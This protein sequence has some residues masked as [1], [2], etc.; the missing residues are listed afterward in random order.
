MPRTALWTS[1][2]KT[3]EQEITTGHYAA[4]DKLPTEAQLSDRFGVNR[5][6][7]RRALVDLAES[8][9]VYAR[10]GA[11][12]F[13]THTPTDYP[14]GRRVRFTQSITATGRTPGRKV[15]LHETRA[16]DPK[17]ADALA[18]QPGAPVHVSEGLSLVDSEVLAMS[19][20]VYPA[21]R[22]PNFLRHLQHEQ[23][24][25]AAFKAEGVADYTRASTRIDAKL[26]SPTLALHLQLPQGA[27]I[28][29]TI[30]INVD[31]DGVP[32]EYGRTWFAGDRVTLTL[33]EDD[34][35]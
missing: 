12:V 32:I 3:L 31:G 8:G 20:G 29:R 21:E 34:V 2:R 4:G 35:D 1:I 10:R 25:T 9:L 33:A 26:A 7:I 18:I 24:V 11:G 27:P 6:T 17:E 5:H 23:S 22:F 15:L 13:V 16:A 14:I 30:G 28:L 19:R